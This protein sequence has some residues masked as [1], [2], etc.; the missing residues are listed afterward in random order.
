MP[1]SHFLKT[2]ATVTWV[3]SD[4]D[5]ACLTGS[6]GHTGVFGTLSWWTAYLSRLKED[7]TLPLGWGCE[8]KLW[9]QDVYCTHHHHGGK[10]SLRVLKFLSKSQHKC[11]EDFFIEVIC[12]CC[13]LE[14][15]VWDSSAQFQSLRCYFIYSILYNDVNVKPLV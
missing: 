1:K 2:I 4:A 9:G 7:S 13:I 14:V 6:E 10:E 12:L 3:I 11:E 5:C 15:R 8:A